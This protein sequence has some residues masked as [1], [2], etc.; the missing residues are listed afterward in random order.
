M[1][2]GMTRLKFLNQALRAQSILVVAPKQACHNVCHKSYGNPNARQ[3][4]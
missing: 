4:E 3:K 2:G 1:S